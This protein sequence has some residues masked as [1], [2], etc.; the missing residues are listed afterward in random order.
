MYLKIE[1]T[2]IAKQRHRTGKYGAYDP[3]SDQKNLLKLYFA[4]QMKNRGYSK[5]PDGPILCSMGIFMP[6]PKNCSKK[7]LKLM[8]GSPVLTKPDIDNIQKF[9]LDVLNDIAYSDDKLITT[10]T[11]EKAY[12]DRPRVEIYLIPLGGNMAGKHQFTVENQITLEQIGMLVKQA[13]VLG[14]SG[15]QVHRVYA[16]VDDLGTH[17]Y[18][19]IDEKINEKFKEN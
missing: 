8:E 14:R 15:S 19:D 17:L 16:E 13:N 10:I 3:Q 12:S 4:S 2:P 5:L 18:F 11:C 1:H 9:Y 7:R 6:K